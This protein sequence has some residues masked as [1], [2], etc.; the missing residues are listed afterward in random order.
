LLENYQDAAHIPI[1]KIDN[2][3]RPKYYWNSIDPL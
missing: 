1:V 2:V 3:E